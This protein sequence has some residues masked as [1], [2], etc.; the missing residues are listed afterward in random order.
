[1]AEKKYYDLSVPVGDWT[2]DWMG[3]HF[4]QDTCLQRVHRHEIP[5][6][7][8]LSRQ[9][10]EYIGI[11]H[12]GTHL[13]GPTHHE[14]GATT[15]DKIPLDRFYGTG[16]IVDFRYMNKWQIVTAKDLED[17]KPKIEEGDIVLMNTGWHHYWR[18]NDYVY[19]NHYPGMYKEAGEWLLAKKVRM[20]G[21]TWGATDGPLCHY[22]LRRDNLYHGLWDEY[23]QETGKDADNE[24]PDYEPCHQ[25][26]S[27][28]MIP[29][30]ENLGGEIDEV[31]GMRCTIAAFPYRFAD[32]G[33]MVRV[34]AIVDK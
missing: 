20:V 18:V 5:I 13:D 30:I 3:H 12:K 29:A 16:V 4:A 19:Y 34:V 32:P 25:I 15:C 17:A 23:M 28:N 24:F 26:F 1:M 11:W 8:G 27:S 2:P 10:S 33:H 9:V 21:G 22:P 31:T 14:E 6:E 7:P